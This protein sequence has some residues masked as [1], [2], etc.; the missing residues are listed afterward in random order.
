MDTDF[1]SEAYKK[2]Y[3]KQHPIFF[4]NGDSS[5][6]HFPDQNNEI[7][8]TPISEYK[9]N[10]MNDFDESSLYSP[11][12]ISAG[13]ASHL[14]F[15]PCSENH[16]NKQSYI[17]PPPSLPK[18]SQSLTSVKSKPAITKSL[19]PKISFIYNQK[20]KSQDGNLSKFYSNNPI[21]ENTINQNIKHTHESTTPKSTPSNT[22]TPITILAAET[23][24]F[25][26]VNPVPF[27]MSE[28]K[29]QPLSLKISPSK[30][31]MKSSLGSTSTKNR[32]ASIS[33]IKSSLSIN[34]NKYANK[35]NVHPDDSNWKPITANL[36]KYISELLISIE[37]FNYRGIQ[38]YFNDNTFEKKVKAIREYIFDITD[39]LHISCLTGL[40]LAIYTEK[41]Y[42]VAQ[43]FSEEYDFNPKAIFISLLSL[44]VKMSNPYVST[45]QPISNKKIANAT[46]LE[47]TAVDLA[48]LEIQI[49]SI[50]NYNLWI[51]KKEFDTFYLR[52]PFE[53]SDTVFSF[54]QYKNRM[55]KRMELIKS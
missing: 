50:L 52:H 5:S 10:L 6:I 37:M 36:N 27:N 40:F 20:T 23:D 8:S 13:L 39:Y 34:L 29:N 42:N 26:K 12:Y 51:S 24:P 46:S 4:I 14:S 55:E 38:G 15:F 11:S 28:I 33:S 43:N 1:N 17:Y 22:N 41:L 3:V 25:I 35:L 2:K 48:S 7:L 19:N 18:Y 30:D 47:Y 16:R 32:V 54:I 21:S 49:T 31:S 9:T 45:T 44:S 53:L